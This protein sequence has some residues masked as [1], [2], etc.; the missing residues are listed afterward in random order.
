M[1][2]PKKRDSRAVPPT[3]RKHWSRFRVGL[4]A[5]VVLIIP[6]YL[7]F[8][9]DIPFTSGY[10]VTAVFESANNLRA[11]S[12]VRIAGVNVGRV[13]SVARYKD[14]NLS[15]VEMEISEDG[16]PIHEDATLKIRP[17]IFLEGNFFVDLRPGTPGSPDVPDGGTIGVTQTSTPVQLDQLLTALQ[18]DSREDLQHVLEE[19]GAALNS[20]PTPEQDAE[21]PESVR[22]LTGAQGLNNAAAPGARA[23][24]NATI[25]NDA[26]R[27]EKPGDLAKTIASVARLSRTLES[28]EG[29]LQDLIV[30]F[31]LTASAF[32]NQS[33]ALSETIR[34]LGPTLATAR[35]ALRS[36]DAALPSTR[37][38]AREILPGVRETAATVNASFP[39]IEQTRALL[40]PDELQGLMA[41]LTPAT[42]DLARLTNASIRLLPEIDDFSQC[43]AKVILPTGNVGLEDG[44]LTNRRSD[45]SI[46]ESY[47]EFWYGL[48]GLTSAGQ[49]FDGNGAYLRA[50][51][52]G[53]QWNVAP[54]ISR[55]AAGG[56]VEKTLTGLA[57]QRPLGTRPLYSARSPAIKTDVPCRSNPVPD[58][59]GPQA[60]PGAA[61]RSIQVPTPP[62]VERRV[63]TPTTP[64]ARTAASDDTSARTASVGSELLSRLSPL[65]NGGGR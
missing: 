52:A 17:R 65:A 48:V 22:G 37:A 7:A 8:T 11:G 16:L 3:K 39:W 46:V 12:P 2:P 64:P 13:K 44:A 40:G 19:Y 18:S 26:I 34:L 61:P 63:E 57:T 32:A 31:N 1:S 51:A 58:L 53:G 45:G 4:I 9:K 33:G 20:K 47:K 42:K 27:G 6:V 62:P 36:V 28:R 24:R 38:W 14:T 50:T 54:G 49:G 29:Q 55:Y 59:N 15:Q 30:N 25:V 43:F 21:L 5:I 41:E 60:G 10:R 23:L 56:T 35:S